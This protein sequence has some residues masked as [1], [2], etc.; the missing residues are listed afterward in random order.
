MVNIFININVKVV[1]T[2]LIKLKKICLISN[3]VMQ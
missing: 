3:P 2:D 1:F